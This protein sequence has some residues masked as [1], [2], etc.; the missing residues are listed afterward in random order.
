MIRENYQAPNDKQG[1]LLEMPLMGFGTFI[2][3][4]FDEIKDKAARI[5]TT[6][7]SIVNA[8]DIGYRHLD[9]AENY[10]NLEAVGEALKVAFKPKAQGGLG[11]QREDL[12]L[13][14]KANAPFSENHIDALLKSV[15]VN[16]FDLFLI[17]HCQGS[18]FENENNLKE[19]WSDLTR[20]DRAKIKRVG[21]SN[22]YEP[23]LSRL[24]AICEKSALIKP[25]A[26]EIEVNIL[27]KNQSL[28][29]YC[30]KQDIKLIAYSPLGYGVVDML[31]SNEALQKLADD[32]KATP[33]QAALAWL[34]AKR[35][36]VIPK[37]THQERLKENYCSSNFIE[38]VRKNDFSTAL[39]KERDFMENGLS[40]TAI[41]SK[42][43]GNALTWDVFPDKEENAA[44]RARTTVK[45]AK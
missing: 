8:L 18:L 45:K 15:Q 14:M 19:G 4:E 6:I 34:M 39:D 35:I 26:N 21:V 12:W 25:F 1:T 16:Y 22:F 29:E 7:D 33:A 3:I 20:I 43:H 37:T 32:I 42:E 17:H 38:L 31:L 41:E 30:Q 44:K 28:V 40:E 9:L 36:A 24:L 13:T 2:G 23:H 5:K 11:L 27:S 10:G